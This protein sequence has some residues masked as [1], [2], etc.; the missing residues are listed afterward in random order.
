[1]KAKRLTAAALGVIAVMALGTSIVSAQATKVI[2]IASQT[3]LSSGSSDVGASM[4]N[5]VEL[6]IDQL[7]GTLKDMGF[8]VQFVYYDDQGKPDVGVANAQQIVADP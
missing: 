4:R 8:D 2:K 7:S 3:P 6:A 1:M 5:S